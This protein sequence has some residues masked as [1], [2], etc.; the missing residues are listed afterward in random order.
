LTLEEYFSKKKLPDKLVIV[1]HDVD[2]EPE[3]ALK[4]ARL[5]SELNIKSTYYF[6]TNENVFVG[7]IIREVNSLGHEIGYHY[8]VL[9]ETFGNYN[10]A[11]ILFEHNLNKFKPFCDVKTIAQHGSPLIGNLNATSL[12]GVYEILKKILKGDKVFTT[13]INADIW[14]KYNFKDFGI[15]GEAYISVDFKNIFYISDTAMCWN[16]KY[17]L[18]DVTGNK[19]SNFREINIKTTNDI[20]DIIQNKKVDRIYI[21]VHPDQWRDK[22][23]DWAKWSILK[24]VRNAGKMVLKIGI[25]KK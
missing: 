10:E 5:E 17:R 14:K 15:I 11:I 20:I 18:K 2:D 4:M 12:S 9:D 3:Y 1:R 13:Q 24:N 7:N 19:S 8:E 22:F 16:N 25:K 6:R 23:I 21:L